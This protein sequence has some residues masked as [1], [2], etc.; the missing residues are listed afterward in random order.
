MSSDV[1]EAPA[2]GLDGQ[3]FDASRYWSKRLHRSASLEATGTLP[4]DGRYQQ[5][6]YR[7]KEAAIRRVLRPWRDGLRGVSVLNVGCGGGYFEPFFAACGASRLMGVDFVAS[8]VERLQADR[9]E[10]E[11]AV[12][13]L[14][15]PLPASLAGRSFDL[16]TAIDVLYHVVDDRRFT[17]ALANLCS[18]CRPDGGLLLWTDAPGRAAER[19]A[20]H[21]RYR[22]RSAYDNILADH[23]LSI[24]RTT[25]MYCCFDVYTSWSERLARH[26][27]FTYPAMYA[28]DRLFAARGWRSTSNHCLVAVRGQ[29]EEVSR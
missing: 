7:L 8:A 5:W 18:L 16:V 24:A 15:Q 19:G 6:L 9:P 25:P 29:A 23:G 10:F 4:F 3:A 1:H 17:R 27:R 21:C 12:A 26:P 11:Y 20:T 28:F 22:D 14:T 2:T 13:D